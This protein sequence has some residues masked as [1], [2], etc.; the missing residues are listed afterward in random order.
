MFTKEK[1]ALKQETYAFH[2]HP[3]RNWGDKLPMISFTMNSG[4][5]SSAD[6]FLTVEQAEQVI[7]LLQ[8]LITQAKALPEEDNTEP[9]LFDDTPF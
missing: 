1:N 8:S 5:G 7:E 3:W 9:V 2:G 6:Q 4:N